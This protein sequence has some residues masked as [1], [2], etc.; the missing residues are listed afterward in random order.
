MAA[1]SSAVVPAVNRRVGILP[2]LREG[3]DVEQVDRLLDPAQ[4]LVHHHPGHR[5]PCGVPRAEV[6]LG[7]P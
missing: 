6:R 1:V 3:R 7:L 5:G 4:D 2:V